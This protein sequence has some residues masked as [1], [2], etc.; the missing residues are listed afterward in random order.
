MVPKYHQGNEFRHLEKIPGTIR[1]IHY[2]LCVLDPN[3]L[4]FVEIRI[5]PSDLESVNRLKN[6]TVLAKFNFI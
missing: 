6:S 5:L 1:R 3:P 2:N 4:L